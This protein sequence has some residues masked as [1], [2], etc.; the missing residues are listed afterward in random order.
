MSYI[1]EVCGPRLAYHPVL[2]KDCEIGI[3]YEI[4]T[5]VETRPETTVDLI[6]A[7]AAMPL[8]VAEP[9]FLLTEYEPAVAAVYS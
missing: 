1:C 9:L 8:P 2:C 6:P 5:R 3:I 7:E 4:K